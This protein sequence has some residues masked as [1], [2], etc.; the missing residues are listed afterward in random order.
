MSERDGWNHLYLYDG[1]TGRG[2]EPDHEGPVGR[3]RRRQG[4]HDGAAD[5]VPRERHVC[6]RRI[7]TSCTTTA[8]TSTAPASRRSRTP[9][10]CTPSRSRRTCSTTSTSARASTCRRCW[11]CAARATA[12]RSMDARARR[13]RRRCSPPAGKRRRS[14]VAKGRDGTTDIYGV[15]IRPTNFDP[16]KKYPVIENIYA[17]PQ[18]SFVPKTFAAQ[19]GMQAHGGARLHR[20]ADRRH[21]HVEPLEGVSRRRVAR[22]SAMPGFPDRILWHKAVAAKYP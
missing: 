22:T 20:R 11:S 14:F 9:T 18:D 4:G 17:G 12:R 21:G 8:S 1:A 16:T 13:R 6:R 3:A 7:R 10:R 5:L 19:L 2:E 15:I